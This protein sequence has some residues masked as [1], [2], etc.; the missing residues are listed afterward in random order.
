M[1]LR[2]FLLILIIEKSI[3][4]AVTNDELKDGKQSIIYTCY[5]FIFILI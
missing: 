4:T 2:F 5:I 1:M 3:G